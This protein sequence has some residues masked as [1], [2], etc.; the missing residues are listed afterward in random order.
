MHGI[1]ERWVPRQQIGLNGRARLVIREDFSTGV[2][3]DRGREASFNIDLAVRRTQDS[4]K[5]NGKHSSDVL[6]TF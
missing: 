2:F 5:I 3:Y 1:G 4:V 6:R